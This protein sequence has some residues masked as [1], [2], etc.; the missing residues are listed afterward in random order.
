MSHGRCSEFEFYTP[1]VAESNAGYCPRAA[2]ML[3]IRDAITDPKL[4]ATSFEPA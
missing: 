4:F 1:R 2:P 3:T